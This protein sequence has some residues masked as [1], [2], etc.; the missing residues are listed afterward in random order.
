MLMKNGLVYVLIMYYICN[1][2]YYHVNRL[3]YIDILLKKLMLHYDFFCQ[4]G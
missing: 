1:R 4:T 2:P 3:T